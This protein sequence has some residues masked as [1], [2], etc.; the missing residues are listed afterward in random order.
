LFRIRAALL[1]SNVSTRESCR[2]I[3]SAFRSIQ[4]Q[5][6]TLVGLAAR[7]ADHPGPAADQRDRRMTRPLQPGQPHH[8][9][10]A[11][12]VEGV[13]RRVEADVGRERRAAQPVGETRR[14]VLDEAAGAQGVEEVRHSRQS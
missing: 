10:Q 13:R 12:D 5:H 1:P 6:W 2:A 7:V 4:P 11:P 14:H 9:D 3:P 8:R